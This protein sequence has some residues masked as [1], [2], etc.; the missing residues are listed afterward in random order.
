MTTFL[1][2]GKTAG[3]IESA[4]IA[5]IPDLIEISNLNQALEHKS[6]PD[7]DPA[8]VLVATSVGDRAHFD[9]LVDIA[10]KLRNQIFLI[11]ISDEIS[12]SDYKRLVRTGGADWVSAKAAS[13]EIAEIVA[14]QK[15]LRIFSTKQGQS[16][17]RTQPVTVAFVPS[18]GGVGNT[19]LIIESAVCLKTNKASQH[20]SVC[21]VDLDFQT[22]HVCD[23]LDVEP[24]LQI[25]E[26]ANAPERLDDHLLDSFKTHHSSDIDVFAAPRSK[27][28]S[29]NMDINAL[30]ALFTMIGK[31]YDLILVDFPVPWFSWTARVIAACDGLVV[32]GLNTIPSLRQLAETLALV[33]TSAAS[34]NIG[35]ALNRCEKS[36][37]GSVAGRKQ[38]ERVLPNEELFFIANHGEAIEGANMGVPMTLGPAARKLRDEFTGLAKFCADVKSARVVSV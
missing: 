19:T 25:A 8:T 12:A 1:L 32:T 35:I 14:K 36:F 22:S 18:A 34:A 23:Y 17:P 6:A 30:D 20:R 9:R 10:A 31:R 33:R 28:P 38:V 26:F 2:R 13:R 15:A 4:L 7:N 27:F 24:R 29:E 21:V 11:L 16:S 3:A 5:N 37:F